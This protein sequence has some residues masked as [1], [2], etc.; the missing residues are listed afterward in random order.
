MVGL[1]MSVGNLGAV[2]A[3]T[4]LAWAAGTWGWRPTFF[5]IGGISLAMAI[6]ML[7]VTRDAPR[8]KTPDV[9]DDD[10]NDS[11]SPGLAQKHDHDHF[12]PAVLAGGHYVL[13]AFMAR[14]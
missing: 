8:S 11:P 13:R 12:L 9:P 5:I 4:P 10:V 14:P 7:T 6:V 3:T 2:V 1:L